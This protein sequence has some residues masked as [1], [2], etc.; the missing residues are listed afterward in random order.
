MEETTFS[1]IFS[2]LEDPRLD[3]TKR[4]GLLDIILL[5][6]CA[7]LCGADSWV[8][9]EEFGHIRK[10]W[11]KSFLELPSGIPSQDTIGRVF[12]MI[13]GKAFDRCFME[14]VQTLAGLTSKVIAIDGKQIRG[15]H[16]NPSVVGLVRPQGEDS[17]H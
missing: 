15:N 11:L 10:E 12:S 9:V 13:N 8:D 6:I 3:R 4:H 14:W 1:I 17:H 16:S 5:T 7:V 2:H